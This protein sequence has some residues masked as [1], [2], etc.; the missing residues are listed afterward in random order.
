M[1][2]RSVLSRQRRWV[3]IGAASVIVLGI[4]T[5]L[6]AS[7]ASRTSLDPDAATPGGTRALAELLRDQGISI[8]RTT[9]GERAMTTGSSTTL[10]VA[11]PQLLRREDVQ[12]LEGL[13]SDVILLGPVITGSGYLGVV[14]S[15]TA[16]IEDREAQCDLPA[17]ALSGD[18]RTGGAAF[19]VAPSAMAA[20]GLGATTECFP[21]GDAP[22][23]VRRETTNGANHTVLGSADFMTNEWIDQ[24]GNASLALNLTGQKPTLV[25][26]LPTPSYTGRQTLTSLLPDGVWPLL[27]VAAVIALTLAG[28]RG[29]RLGPVVVEPLPVAVRASETTEGRARI[30]QRYRTRDQAAAHLRAHIADV[31]GAHLGLPPT[32]TA[33][34]VVDAVAQSAGRRADEVR[35]VLYGPPPEGDS[36]LV[37]LGRQLATLEQE[38]RHA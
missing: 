34:A 16:D 2:G 11:Y 31:L 30:Y 19:T 12:R 9:D 17:A 15:A 4:T 24:A 35:V 6:M 32:A 10:V 25:W 7:T 21:D 27:G 13:S 3:A 26:W 14:S 18:A 36:A 28:W 22:T 29:R 38:V 5:A 37:T 8:E 1:S 20:D 33:D 23:V